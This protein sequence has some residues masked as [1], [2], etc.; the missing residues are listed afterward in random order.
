MTFRAFMTAVALALAAL[1]GGWTTERPGLVGLPPP[2]DAGATVILVLDNGFHTDVAVPR[3]A[4]EARSGPLGEAV[5]ALAPGDWVLIGWGDETFYVEQG[6]IA[7]RLPDGARAF[8]RPGNRSVVMIDPVFAPERRHDPARLRRLPL[9]AAGLEA[10]SARVE[11]SLALEHGRARVAAVRP[12]DDARFLASNETFWF[13]RLCN[14]WTADVLNAGGLAI[15]PIQSATSAAVIAAV[16][17]SAS[18]P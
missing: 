11:S 9:S 4:L 1:A 2:G 7:E 3:A 12:G 16:D 5:R 18:N 17:R 8:F 15:R 10:L 6:P 13:G 14:H